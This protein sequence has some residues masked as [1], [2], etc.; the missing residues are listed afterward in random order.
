MALVRSDLAPSNLN[1][2]LV[3]QFP[4]LVF[5]RQNDLLT[6]F[7]I[8]LAAS[9]RRLQIIPLLKFLAVLYQLGANLVRLKLILDRHGSLGLI[10]MHKSVQCVNW[11]HSVILLMALRCDK[12]SGLADHSE[13][14]NVFV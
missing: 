6:A 5:R 7:Q 2:E 11:L 12:V 10:Q 1:Q 3:K 13:R 9:L 14:V 4:N 8:D